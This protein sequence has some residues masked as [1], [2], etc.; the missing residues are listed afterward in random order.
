M[1]WAFCYNGSN[2]I[3]FNYPALMSDGKLSTN[4]HTACANNNR[5][6]RQNGIINNYQYRQF[7]QKNAD[8]II[9]QNQFSAC[10]NSGTCQSHLSSKTKTNDKYLYKSCADKSV[11]FGYEQSDLKSAYLSRQALESRL[12]API[13]TQDQMLQ[14]FNY[15]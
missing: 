2:N 6:K 9:L 3:H 13:L 4:W 15:N 7:L 1:S 5:L 8:S 11:P 12:H 14:K 10:N